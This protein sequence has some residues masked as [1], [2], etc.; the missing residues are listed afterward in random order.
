[1]T[2]LRRLPSERAETEMFIIAQNT[3]HR[4]KLLSMLAFQGGRRGMMSLV[5]PIHVE[6]V[7]NDC[8]VSLSPVRR[9]PG[10]CVRRGG[11]HWQLGGRPGPPRRHLSP[12]L[13]QLEAGTNAHHRIHSSDPALFQD[14]REP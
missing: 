6:W 10:P 11:P 7:S 13:L 3:R 2:P 8:T 5:R 1:M 12:D 14:C 4:R 9:C